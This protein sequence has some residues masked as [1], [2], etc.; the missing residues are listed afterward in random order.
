V[1]QRDCRHEV[2]HGYF[3]ALYHD[4]VTCS[5]AAREWARW[6]AYISGRVAVDDDTTLTAVG[7]VNVI[8]AGVAPPRWQLSSA[9]GEFRRT[10]WLPRA[11]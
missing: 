6:R 9:A 4:C 8:S 1:G 11:F 7:Q 2:E 5:R 3:S 10:V